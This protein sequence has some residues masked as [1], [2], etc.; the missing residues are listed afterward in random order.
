[1]KRLDDDFVR[2]AVAYS[3]RRRPYH[4]EYEVK[5]WSWKR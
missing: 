5:K 2:E 1:M 3:D 4:L